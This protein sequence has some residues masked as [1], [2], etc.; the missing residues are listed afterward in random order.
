VHLFVVPSSDERDGLAVRLWT[1][2]KGSLRAVAVPSALHLLDDLPLNAA[3][4]VDKN[5]L[6]ERIGG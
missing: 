6:R 5:R 3:G 4:K 2:L 1:S